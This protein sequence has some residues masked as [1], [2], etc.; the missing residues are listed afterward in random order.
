MDIAIPKMNGWD[1][2]RMLKADPE[3]RRIPVLALTAHALMQERAKEIGFDG[4]LAKPIEPRRVL[5]AVES[6]LA[7]KLSVV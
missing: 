7:M 3:T 2:T 5:A 6:L 1:A 4:Y